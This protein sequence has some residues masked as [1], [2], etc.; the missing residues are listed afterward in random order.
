METYSIGQLA[1]KADVSNRTLRYYEELGLITP[2]NRGSNRYRYYDESHMQRLATIKMLQD[3]GFALKEI[4]AALSPMLDPSGNVTYAGQEIAKRIYEALAIQKAKLAE[5]QKE[6]AQTVDEL[7]RTMDQL[8]TCFGCKLSSSLDDCS[9]CERGP[10]EVTRLA[11]QNLDM[12][13]ELN[14][15]AGAANGAKH[16]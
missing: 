9:K 13:H 15:Y 7:G 14:H 3:S 12:K 5:R 10:S 1:K 16:Q 8:K 11:N 4:V 2:K 6:I